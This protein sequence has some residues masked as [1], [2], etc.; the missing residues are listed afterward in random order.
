MPAYGAGGL[1]VDEDDIRAHG[2]DERIRGRSFY[3]DINLLWE[4][5]TQLGQLSRY[6][7]HLAP[8]QRASAHRSS[9]GDSQP[10][11]CLIGEG[12]AIRSP[13]CTDAL[14]AFPP[15]SCVSAAFVWRQLDVARLR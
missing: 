4:M 3:E 11:V 15:L 10:G 13:L 5:V 1:L 6:P 8:Q 7:P 9:A 12:V 2:R 14:A